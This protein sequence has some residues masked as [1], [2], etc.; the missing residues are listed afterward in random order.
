MTYL[1]VHI[2]ICV[3]VENV[4][5]ILQYFSVVQNVLQTSLYKSGTITSCTL[6]P[7]RSV[8]TLAPQG[9]NIKSESIIT[10]CRVREFLVVLIKIVG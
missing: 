3:C 2:C 5:H 1:C 4:V 7:A 6:L 8:A 10:S 9:G